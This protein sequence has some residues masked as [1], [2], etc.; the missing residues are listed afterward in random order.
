ML[1]WLLKSRWLWQ[2]PAI[3]LWTIPHTLSGIL[4]AYA[5][6]SADAHFW[7]GFFITLSLATFWEWFEILTSLS[8]HE[9]KLNSVGDIIVAQI[10]YIAGFVLFQNHISEENS[11]LV[12]A[13]ATL[14]ILI[15]STLGWASHRLYGKK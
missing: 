11:V 2:A 8:K 4:I 10:G 14:I 5:S 15:I 12:V 1:T 9:P 6:V 7:I 13:S 3:D